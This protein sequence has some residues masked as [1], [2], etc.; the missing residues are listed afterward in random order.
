MTSNEE[1]RVYREEEENQEMY[2]RKY[3]QYNQDYLLIQKKKKNVAAMKHTMS[4][5]VSRAMQKKKKKLTPIAGEGRN[6]EAVL[7]YGKR[8]KKGKKNK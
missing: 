8:E 2:G 3:L 1:R 5:E 6:R 7:I 4:P